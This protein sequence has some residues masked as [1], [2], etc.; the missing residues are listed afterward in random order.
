MAK[1]IKFNLVC[2]GYQVR[3]LDDLRNHFSIEDILQY[4]RDKVL[5]KW[6]T[7][8]GYTEELE[9]VKSIQSDSPLE[10]IERLVS[11]FD[12]ETDKQKIEY[13]TSIIRYREDR[14]E[15]EKLQRNNDSEVRVFYNRYFEKYEK[16]KT[17]IM[18]NPLNKPI[19]QAAINEIVN[20]Y[21]DIFDMPPR[22]CRKR[23]NR[24]GHSS[25]SGGR[26]PCC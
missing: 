15:C 7:V 5:E 18:K 12:V 11:I 9:A 6:L 26:P 3:T 24:Q 13:A 2:D 16:L 8:R 22:L 21:A 19:I 10:T 14:I 25:A 23:L 4:Y 17:D 1:T 20:R